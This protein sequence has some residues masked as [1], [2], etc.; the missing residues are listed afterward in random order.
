MAETIKAMES[1]RVLS[2]WISVSHL[3]DHRGYLIDLDLA[4][5][6]KDSIKLDMVK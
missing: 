6:S 3:E 1:K 2:P 5:V 4:G